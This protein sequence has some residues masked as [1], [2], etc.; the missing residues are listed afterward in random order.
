MKYGMQRR[1]LL[2]VGS[3]A[4][5]SIAIGARLGT[6]AQ[7]AAPHLDEKDATAQSLG[8][9]HD[10]TKV[11]KAKFAKYKAGETCANCQLY[12]GKPGQAWGPCPIFA[13]KG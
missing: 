5:A 7:A 3:L 2:K 12:Q 6:S 10:A 8:Y 1:D 9:K 13:G 4:L 11:D